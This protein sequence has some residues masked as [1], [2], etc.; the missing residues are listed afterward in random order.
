[1]NPSKQFNKIL[2]YTFLIVT[3]INFALT[4]YLSF[5]KVG[6]EFSGQLTYK[7]E[8][9]SPFYNPSWPLAVKGIYYLKIQQHPVY[10]MIF[11]G[12]DFLVTLFPFLITGFLFYLMGMAV[13]HFYPDIASKRILLLIHFLAA[14]YLILVADFA[15]TYFFILPYFIIVALIPSLAIH[16]ALLFPDK[17]KKIKIRFLLPLYVIPFLYSLIYFYFFER[18][19]SLWLQ[20]QNVLMAYVFFA[21]SFW[22]FRLF[23]VYRRK[24]QNDFHKTLTKYL[25]IGQILIFVVHL[26]PLMVFIF[27][28]QVPALNFF[29]PFT[30]LTPLT[31][32]IGLLLARLKQSQRQL[33]LIEKRNAVSQL[34]AGLTHEIKNPLTFIY[35]NIEPLYEEINHLSQQISSQHLEEIK[36]ISKNIEDGVERIHLLLLGL[37]YFNPRHSPAIQE[38]KIADSLRQ[39]LKIFK[40]RI[41]KRIK[42]EEDFREDLSIRASPL[43]LSQLW[44]N[45]LS[46]AIDSIKNEG[47]IRIELYREK[48]KIKIKIKD[49]GHGISPE[50]MNLIFDPFFSTKDEKNGT[51]LGMSICLEIVE[52][53]H[54]Q[55]EVNSK[56]NE[57]T[58]VRV[59]F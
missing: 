51:G 6:K 37:N 36:A 20:L 55:I 22:I 16:F 26:I 11:S 23:Q 47:K 15:S 19:S 3:F 21:S 54:G 59:T 29:V 5:Q 49:S 50:V 48:D 41:D 52:K 2:V 10:P 57:G 4:F 27:L 1:M 14:N 32:F 43:E 13:F 7:N 44:I 45:L 30:L 31:F 34:M 17:K 56:V 38:V 53:L 40:Y 39:S 42:I 25:A 28:D 58:E 33:I 8:I 35:S 24:I 12:K 18:N 9:I 46:N